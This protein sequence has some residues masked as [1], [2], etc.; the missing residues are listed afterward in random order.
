MAIY[1][2]SIACSPH[3]TQQGAVSGVFYFIIVTK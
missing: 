3:T 1:G 2:F